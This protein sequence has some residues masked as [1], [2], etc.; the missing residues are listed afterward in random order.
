MRPTPPLAILSEMNNFVHYPSQRI[1][2]YIY[3]L[4]LNNL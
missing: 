4:K 2:I 3:M 1:Y